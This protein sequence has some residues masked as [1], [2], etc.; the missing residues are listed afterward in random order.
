MKNVLCASLAFIAF[1]AGQA[2]SNDD[3]PVNDAWI[4]TKVKA[5]LAT[6]SDTSAS[7][8]GVTTKDGV[9]VLSGN[10]RSEEEADRAEGE[11]KLISG[12][13]EVRNKIKVRE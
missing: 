6:Q 11:A 8:I 3:Q 10:V 1:G 4:T 9:V 2:W 13:K 5:A 7:D 12:V